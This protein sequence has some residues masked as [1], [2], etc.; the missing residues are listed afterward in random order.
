MWQLPCQKQ[1]KAQGLL[2]TKG[3][4]GRLGFYRGLW[5]EEHWTDCCL[6]PVASASPIRISALV[7]MSPPEPQCP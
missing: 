2:L 1:P 4:Q 7:V 5:G 6:Y 3:E